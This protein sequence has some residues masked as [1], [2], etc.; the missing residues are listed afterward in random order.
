MFGLQHNLILLQRN[1]KRIVTY[2][3]IS[4]SAVSKNDKEKLFNRLQVL[5]INK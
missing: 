5:K 3:P 1:N 4:L 2:P